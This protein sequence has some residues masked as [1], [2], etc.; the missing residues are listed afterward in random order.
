MPFADQPLQAAPLN[1]GITG[2]A[3]SQTAPM[4]LEV[5][6]G[7]ITE[8]DTGAVHNFT[9]AESNAFV[10]D[11]T[12]PTQVFMAIITNDVS[13][14]LWV[15]AYVDDGFNARGAIPTGFR[16]LATVAW[17]SIAANETDLLNGD[18]FRRVWQ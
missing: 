5:A 6:T 10:A 9:P 11:A 13:V 14:D 8:Y 15:D 3:V 4:T 12:D 2:L 17:F 1:K 16:I 18:V 7:T